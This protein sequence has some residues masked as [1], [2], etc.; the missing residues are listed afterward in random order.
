MMSVGS[1]NASIFEISKE[2]NKSVAEKIMCIAS[3]KVSIFCEKLCYVGNVLVFLKVLQGDGLPSLICTLC[4]EHLD[5]AYTFKKKCEDT[6]S[7]LRKMIASESIDNS[8]GAVEFSDDIECSVCDATFNTE[9][10]LKS[11]SKT[12][13]VKKKKVICK[14]S[15]TQESLTCKI[16]NKVYLKASNLSAHM[17][18]HTGVKPFEC[19]VCS[20]RFTQGDNTNY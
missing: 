13:T 19:N 12:H 18:T 16:C 9:L 4:I 2:N 10:E 14:Q 6:D 20:K 15:S 17:G 1:E 3:V 11:H 8:E 5:I 7:V